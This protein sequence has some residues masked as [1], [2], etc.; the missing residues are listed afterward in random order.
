MKVTFAT[1]SVSSQAAQ[2]PRD[3]AGTG[4]AERRENTEVLPDAV[5]LRPA[6]LAPSLVPSSAESPAVAPSGTHKT[7]GM[8][9]VNAEL[10]A[11]GLDKERFQQELLR[12]A[13]LQFSPEA[14]ARLVAYLEER[15]PPSATQSCEQARELCWIASKLRQLGP[16][17]QDPEAVV[18]FLSARGLRYRF[19]QD[20]PPTH[21]GYQLDSGAFQR[22]L[23]GAAGAGG[24]VDKRT[25]RR[26]QLMCKDLVDTFDITWAM[27][28]IRGAQATGKLE[29]ATA[30]KLLATLGAKMRGCVAAHNIAAAFRSMREHDFSP[31]SVARYEA[32][33]AK[34][35]TADESAFLA[36]YIAQHGIE[37]LMTQC[38]DPNKRE[39]MKAAQESLGAFFA[40]RLVGRYD[41]AGESRHLRKLLVSGAISRPQYDVLRAAAITSSSK[42]DFVRGVSFAQRQLGVT[43]SL[44][45]IYYDTW[46]EY[47][48]SWA[49]SSSDTRDAHGRLIETVEERENK[50]LITAILKRVPEEKR[51]RTLHATFSGRIQKTF[52]ALARA[53]TESERSSLLGELA[54][55]LIGHHEAEGPLP[56]G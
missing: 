29:S 55:A 21:N 8:Q 41:R 13:A 27:H 14:Q 46:A 4:P 28:A 54:G 49:S 10:A 6:E 36:A 9:K 17:G 18:R 42:D 48:S 45:A 44:Q 30:D 1:P 16:S 12:L 53:N 51:A 2:D 20:L 3:E 32:L 47:M 35:S 15:Y 23:A 40:P 31:E 38:P 52:D 37:R 50:R 43:L 11:G 56:R 7:I 25:G 24:H 34:S 39:G 19:A 22:A 5:V 26:L 33:V